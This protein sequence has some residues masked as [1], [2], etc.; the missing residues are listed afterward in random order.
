MIDDL[1][2]AIDRWP[3]LAGEVFAFVFDGLD[4]REGLFSI[5]TREGKELKVG[6]TIQM[7]IGVAIFAAPELV[8]FAA[9]VEQGV[10]PAMPLVGGAGRQ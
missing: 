8:Q 4:V 7:D 3:E 10:V 2:D 9:A 1:T 5:R 6:D